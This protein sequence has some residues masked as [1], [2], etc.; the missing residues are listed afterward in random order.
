MH[1][2][3]FTAVHYRRA[4]PLECCSCFLFLPRSR[5]CHV[6]YITGETPV[7]CYIC[8][9]AREV[10]CLCQG[11]PARKAVARSMSALHARPSP[12]Q[13]LVKWGATRFP[14]CAAGGAR[15]L[16][17]PARGM[18]PLE[19]GL[20]SPTLLRVQQSLYQLALLFQAHEPLFAFSHFQL[21]YRSNGYG[22]QTGAHGSSAH[23]RA[24][25][26]PALSSRL[27]QVSVATCPADIGIR[28][29]GSPNPNIEPC[30]RSPPSAWLQRS[31]VLLHSLC[32][33]VGR[34]VQCQA[35]L[36]QR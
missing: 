34:G 22:E 35:E 30:A 21:N 26:T 15:R 4:K 13:P 9:S 2:S 29:L 12:C 28:V 18:A 7:G 24:N 5:L 27:A 8:P 17:L 32:L 20:C 23:V 31:T 25:A 19:Q 1:S 11:W 3:P 10:L 6:Q 36:A 16:P 14:L 33:Q